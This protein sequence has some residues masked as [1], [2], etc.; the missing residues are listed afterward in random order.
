MSAALWGFNVFAVVMTLFGGLL[1]MFQNLMSRR[2]L[3]RLFA[4]R[5]GLLLSITFIEVFPDAWQM[6]VNTA[7]W[8]ALAGF[9]LLFLLENIAMGDSCEEYLEECDVH[10]L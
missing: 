10:Y 4:L 3:W 9:V 8:G 5:A 7:G 6:D 2:A 1:P